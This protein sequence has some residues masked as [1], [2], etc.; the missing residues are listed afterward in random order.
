MLNDLVEKG[1]LLKKQSRFYSNRI[2]ILDHDSE[3]LKKLLIALSPPHGSPPTLSE[4]AENF[5]IEIAVVKKTLKAGI[6][7][8]KLVQVEDNRFVGRTMV[9]KLKVA[10]EN[11]CQ[12]SENGLFTIAD[13]R[14]ETGLGRNFCIVILEYFDRIGHTIRLNEAFR[15]VVDA[16][17]S[18]A[19]LSQNNR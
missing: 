13:F 5:C 11:L 19:T 7:L 18:A 1:H 17:N 3:L 14:D 6:K 10:A 2:D 16:H 15:K 4:M 8:G 9:D 12:N